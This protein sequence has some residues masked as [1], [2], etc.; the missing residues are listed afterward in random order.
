MCV[1]IYLDNVLRTFLH[2]LE[3]TEDKT[4]INADH[5]LFS[6]QRIHLHF[7]PKETEGSGQGSNKAGHHMR[8]SNLSNVANVKVPKTAVPLKAI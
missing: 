4:L 8:N 2:C 1:C 7:N 3:S 5:R 6:L